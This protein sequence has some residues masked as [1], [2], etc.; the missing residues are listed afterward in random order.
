MSCG[1]HGF[2]LFYFGVLWAVM[3]PDASVSQTASG[4]KNKWIPLCRETE[5]SEGERTIVSVKRC[6]RKRWPWQEE[7]VEGGSVSWN[8]LLHRHASSSWGVTVEMFPSGGHGA[9]PGAPPCRTSRWWPWEPCTRIY[10]SAHCRFRS[11]SQRFVVL[12]FKNRDLSCNACR[13]ISSRSGCS[14]Q[15]VRKTNSWLPVVVA[16]SKNISIAPALAR[17]CELLLDHHYR[18]ISGNQVLPLSCKVKRWRRHVMSVWCE[19]LA[20]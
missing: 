2:F 8:L 6:H 5:S 20:P 11:D 1:R 4:D 9:A 19:I 10:L 18:N 14:V 15:S 7:E 16:L 3:W 17:W 12:V 13:R